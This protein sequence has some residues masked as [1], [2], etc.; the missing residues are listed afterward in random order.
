MTPLGPS[1]HFYFLKILACYGTFTVKLKVN[2]EQ[3]ARWMRVRRRL[4]NGLAS[5]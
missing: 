4:S 3:I 2:R 5:A 1:K